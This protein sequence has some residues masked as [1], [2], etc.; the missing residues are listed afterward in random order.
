MGIRIRDNRTTAGIPIKEMDAGTWFVTNLGLFLKAAN[1]VCVDVGSGK[2]ISFNEEFEGQ[3]V[4]VEM[5]IVRNA[6]R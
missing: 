4:D 2:R 1:D 3:P 6:Y 5:Q